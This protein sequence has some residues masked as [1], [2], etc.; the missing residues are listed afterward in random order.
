[1]EQLSGGNQ[2]RMLLALLKSPLSLILLEHPTRGL[3]LESTVYIWSR[4]KERCEEGAAIVFISS[5][6]NREI[7]PRVFFEKIPGLLIYANDANP[8]DGTLR[9]VLIYQL[10][11]GMISNLVS[12]LKE[13]DALNRMEEVFAEIPRVRKD[14]AIRPLS[15]QRARLSGRKQC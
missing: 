14:L 6:L 13:Q 10:P 15:P 5:D 1:V 9:D 8:A 2:Q 12:Q 3:D 11:G 4:L 7:Q